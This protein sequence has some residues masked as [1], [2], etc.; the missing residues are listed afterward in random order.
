M[1]SA[2]RR[3]TALMP[4]LLLSADDDVP[5]NEDAAL[6]LPHV[7]YDG[8]TPAAA[9]APAAVATGGADADTD[10]V[11]ADAS[12]LRGG[13]AAASSVMATASP[14]AHEHDAGLTGDVRRP[15]RRRAVVDAADI[16]CV[17]ARSLV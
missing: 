9:A 5:L 11:A 17:C 7:A 2:C 16:L 8:G 1:S 6:L 12:P 15:L 13:T 4:L 10:A 3:S 14:R